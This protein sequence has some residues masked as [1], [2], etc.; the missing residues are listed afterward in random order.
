[1]GCTWSVHARA[2]L[3]N[4]ILRVK[5][6]DSVHTCGAVIRTHR[7]PHTGSKFVSSVVVDRI[8]GQP[9]TRPTYVLFALKNEYGLEVSY[10]VAWLEVEKARGEV[11]G[12]HAMS[13]IQLRWFHHCRP[14]LF[15][16]GMFLQDRFK[17]NLLAATAKEGNQGEGLFPVAFAI[18]DSENSAN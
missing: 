5:S 15:L 12:D 13:F 7:N 8:R 14:L 6:F 9:L 17:G 2:L 4:G 1:M 18:V 11:Y 10:W 3:A 16:D